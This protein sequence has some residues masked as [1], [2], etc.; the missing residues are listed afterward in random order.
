MNETLL[1]VAGPRRDDREAGRRSWRLWLTVTGW[2][3]SGR[4]GPRRW[5]V[6]RCW[7]P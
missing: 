4:A 5:S 6:A 2:R 1:L 7:R 3:K